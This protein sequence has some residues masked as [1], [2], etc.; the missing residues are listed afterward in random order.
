MPTGNARNVTIN[1]PVINITNQGEIYGL[2]E[3]QQ[4]TPA[5]TSVPVLILG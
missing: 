5:A 4:L 2:I 3:R 1:T